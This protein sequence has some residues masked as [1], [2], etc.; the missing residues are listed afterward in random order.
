MVLL[1]AP[2]ASVNGIV[3][4]NVKEVVPYVPVEVSVA[5]EAEVTVVDPICH[6]LVAS[7]LCNCAVNV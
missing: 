6:V 1:I 7:A 5:A 3:R 4:L 2:A